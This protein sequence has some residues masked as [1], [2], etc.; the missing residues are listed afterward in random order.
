DSTI[1]NGDFDTPVWISAVHENQVTLFTSTTAGIGSSIDNLAPGMSALV[2]DLHLLQWKASTAPD[3]NY[4]TLYGG[5]TASFGAA[6][7]INYTINTSF[8]ITASPRAYYF[9]TATDFS[10]NEGA[11]SMLR[12]LTGVDGTPTAQALSISA[13]PNPFN[14]A[15]TLRYTVPA[16]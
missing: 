4:Y 8:D 11:P 7:L 15:T 6:T 5:S 12:R 16:A 10:G 2:L 9:V 13:Y 14:P 1:V 3:V